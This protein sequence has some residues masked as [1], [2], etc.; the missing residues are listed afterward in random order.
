[1]NKNIIKVLMATVMVAM[2]FIGVSTMVG[3][4]AG[5]NAQCVQSTASGTNRTGTCHLSVSAAAARDHVYRATLDWRHSQFNVFGEVYSVRTG[6]IG[7][8]T[9]GNQLTTQHSAEARGPGTRASVSVIRIVG[10]RPHSQG[11]VWR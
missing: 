7:R 8:A 3:M 6:Y 9:V 5:V 4:A 2:L 1:M 10:Q 11:L